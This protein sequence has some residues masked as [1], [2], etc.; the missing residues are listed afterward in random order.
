MVLVAKPKRTSTI[1]HKKRSGQHH[2]QSK[3]YVKPYWPYLPLLAIVGIGI[4]ANS[5]WGGHV[6]SVLGYSTDVSA[7]QLLVDSNVQRTDAKE[8]SL[9]LNAQLT[10]AAQAKA[11]D[12]AKQNYWSH[13]TPSGIP[14]WTFIS[15]AGYQFQ[16]AGENLA[17]GFDTSYE[18][19][20]AWMN[21]PEHR[22]NVLNQNFSDVG[23]GIT[24]APSYQGNGPETIIVAM[25]GQP[26]PIVSHAIAYGTS[27][28]GEQAQPATVVSQPQAA[29]VSRVGA[30][31]AM[32][33]WVT[34][35]ITA[36][37]TVA[38]LWFILRHGLFL[39][40]AFV[41]SEAFIVHH[42]MLDVLMVSVATLG[43]ILTRTAGFIH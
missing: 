34:L 12:M 32:G 9:Q 35:S 22:A 5:V 39:K 40:R 10:A 43:I 11:N 36:I 27:P 30:L 31:S 18:I 1:H 37:T 17:Y 38:I 26:A 4:I 41:N 23:F 21:S 2:K 19:M 42:P 14:P 13:N 6:H 29:S 7:T 15:K 3:H 8:K 16:A 24:N 20:N 25:Y 33:P 28:S